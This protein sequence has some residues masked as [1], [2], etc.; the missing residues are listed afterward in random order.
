MPSAITGISYAVPEK[1]L[2]HAELCERFGKGV[3]DKIARASGILE[4]RV[5]PENVCASDL[6]FDA[7]KLLIERNRLNPKDFDLLLMGTQTPDYMMPTTACILQE[8]M[9]LPKNCAAFDINLGCS[10]FI[11][12]LGTAR[13]WIEAGM[14]KKALVLAGDTPSKLIHPMDKSAVSI[15]G[16]A[17]CA[18]V[19]EK[20]DKNSLLDFSFGSDGSG[21]SDLIC[22]TS[23]MRRRPTPEDYIEFEDADKNIR[24]NSNMFVDGFKIFN[25]A[26]KIIA[27]EVTEI[28]RR[29]NL[30]IDDIGLFIFHQAGEMIVERSAKRIGIP[31]EKLFYKMHDIGN[32]GGSSV[33]IALTEAAASGRLKPG[34][35]VVLCAFGVGLSWATA[36]IEWSDAFQAA[37]TLADYSDSPA[38]PKNQSL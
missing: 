33:G 26:Y 23:G 6:A 32:C 1:K 4:R 9:G 17:A 12:A 29:N 35:K 28:L 20:A 18:C 8:R 2:T 13:A 14:A 5:A 22:P 37:H 19:V 11:Y 7:S 34:M 31:R 36:L 15:F 3:M 25:F 24:S 21:F 30:D 16:D 27:Q 38:R 10:Q